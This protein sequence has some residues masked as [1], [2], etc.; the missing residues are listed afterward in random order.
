VTPTANGA[1][2][3]G[4]SGVRW[5]IIALCFLA[6]VIA[7]LLRINM[8]VAGT[9]LSDDL[10]F[11][12]VQLGM[13][14][15]AFAW[16]YAAF[17]FPGGVWGDRFGARRTLALLAVGWGGLN[18]LVGLMP[19]NGAASPT[20]LLA[21]LVLL[22]FLMG[23][24]QAP[25]YPVMAG[26]AIRNWFP[27]AAWGVP[28]ALTNAG[29]AFGSAA[30][31][32]LIG[33]LVVS[34]GWRQSFI[35]TAPAALGFAALWWW[36]YRDQPGEHRHVGSAELAYIAGG[37][38][39]ADTAP[40]EPRAWRRVLRDRNVLLITLSYFCSN[41]L[42][43]FFFNWLV[44]YLVESRQLTLLQGGWYAA[45]PWI[46]GAVGA[47]IGGV[48]TDRLT[49]RYNATVGSRWPILLAL[50]GAGALIA[51]VPAAPNA[52]IAVILLSL[53]LALQQFTD[54]IY[55]AATTA[56]SGRD[57]GSACGLLNTGGN[58][59]GGIGALLVP[60][61]VAALGWPAA[62]ATAAGFA[63]IGG[64]LWLWIKVE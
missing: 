62:L 7:Y 35:L 46:T 17:Q 55:W 12:Q 9:A 58:I 56:V 47:M 32:P 42:F 53:C 25:L 36:Y 27:A 11:S 6:S 57:A 13:V 52:L 18:L 48:V 2:R 22:R 63:V 14:L 26:G 44:I 16:G 54:P 4:Y 51:V 34:A 1:A 28:N 15:G 38:T 19:A 23:A 59:V 10:G 41:Y 20:V 31:G 49:R 24:V 29:L 64:V 60:V 40:A 37:R 50:V 33:W 39:A 8:S 5:A 43:Y 61:T 3:P 45:A 30:T 21:A